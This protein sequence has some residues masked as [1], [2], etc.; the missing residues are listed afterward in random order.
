M[1]NDVIEA[2]NQW[3]APKARPS[4]APTDFQIQLAKSPYAQ[5]LA[6][7]VR[8]CQGTRARLPSYFMQAFTIMAHPETKQPW[9][10]PLDL[11]KKHQPAQETSEASDAKAPNLPLPVGAIGYVNSRQK[12]MEALVNSS[13]GYGERW[14]S[15][16][17][18]IMG[19]YHSTRRIIQAT[20]WRS[21]MDTHILE[22]HRRR[23]VEHL[24]YT[25]QLRRG[26]ISRSATWEDS[27]LAK[28]QAGGIIWTGPRSGGFA[29]FDDDNATDQIVVPEFSTLEIGKTGKQVPVFNLR[30]ML[31][32]EHLSKLRLACPSFGGEIMIIKDK[33][34]T[35]DLRKRLWKLEGYIASYYE[36]IP[37]HVAA[38]LNDL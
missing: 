14:K 19:K 13:S 21:D 18:E 12:L 34:M 17:A 36:H 31:G 1:D 15:S 26:Y 23:L 28:R 37:D 5:M 29:N 38:A 4:K 6:T 7:P 10:V 33:R 22:L 9:R 3:H 11:T 16:Y 30:R 20:Q 35:V 24:Q 25:T 32:K 27:T 8:Q 2:K